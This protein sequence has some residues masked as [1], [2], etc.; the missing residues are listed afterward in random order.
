MLRQRRLPFRLGALPKAHREMLQ[1]LPWQKEKGG[2]KNFRPGQCHGHL[3]MTK[4]LQQK[5]R[6]QKTDDD[7]CYTQQPVGW[8]QSASHS[9]DPQSLEPCGWRALSVRRAEIS[10]RGRLEKAKRLKAVQPIAPRC[11][12]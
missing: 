3:T 1:D 4:V 11:G 9:G 10:E 5:A 6:R 7:A 2:G 12:W 8:M